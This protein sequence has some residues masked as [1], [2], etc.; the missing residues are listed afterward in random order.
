M[1]SILAYFD[2][3]PWEFNYMETFSSQMKTSA[4]NQTP[5]PTPQEKEKQ[6]GPML[7]QI[8]VNITEKSGTY[9]FHFIFKKGT[10]L[11]QRSF[12]ASGEMQPL[13]QL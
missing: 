9:L 6:I 2:E 1:S 11:L 8:Q 10:L 3:Q 13:W 12:S 5:H 4:M 7:H